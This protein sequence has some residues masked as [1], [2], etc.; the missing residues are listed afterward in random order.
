M[1]EAIAFSTLIVGGLATAAGMAW[2]YARSRCVGGLWAFGYAVSNS[3]IGVLAWAHHVLNG[4]NSEETY[5]WLLM[6]LVV[7]NIV[8]TIGVFSLGWK[9]SR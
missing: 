8:T 3:A 2:H 9:N 5:L 4:R 7:L 6:P 1:V